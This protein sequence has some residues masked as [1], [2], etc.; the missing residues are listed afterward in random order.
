LT[1]Q[2]FAAE[3]LSITL[4]TPPG[5]VR[6]VWIGKFADALEARSEGEI[7]VEVFDSGQLYSSRD[8]GKA[9]ARGDAGMA[10]VSTASLSRIESNLNVLDLPMFAG[11]SPEEKNEVVDGPLGQD[12]ANR[13]AE[14]MGVVVPGGWYIL[15]ALDTYSTDKVIAS[16]ADL[17]GMQ[18]RIPGAPS[19]IAMYKTLGATPVSMPFT[20][21]PLALQQG[22]VDAIV[23]SDLSVISAKLHESGLKHGF[24][25]KLGVG[26]YMP[27]VS[28]DFW[29]SLTAEQ[30]AMFKETW[31]EYVNGQR[32]A[33]AQEQSEARATLEAAGMDFHKP[34]DEEFEEVRKT[35]MELQPDL[36]SDLDISDEVLALAEQAI[37]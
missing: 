9:V 26:Y 14:K 10:I 16:F 2:A 32:A 24:V 7:E 18:V 35:F 22:T 33:A 27:I 11:M 25:N 20:D 29:E 15:G 23:S 4:D 19:W 3:K 30:Q 28:S 17:E 12:L 37:N 6:N 21:V 31:N 5:H 1:G 8:A 34:S 13:T 36:V